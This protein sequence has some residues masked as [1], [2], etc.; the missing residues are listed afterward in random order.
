MRLSVILLA[1]LLG[2]CGDKVVSRAPW[3]SAA[4]EA[5][6]PAL[7]PGLWVAPITPDCHPDERKPPTAWPDCALAFVIRGDEMRALD[8]EE[9]SVNGKT[10]TTRLSWSSSQLILAAGDPSISQTAGCNEQA[11]PNLTVFQDPKAPP[12]P[13]PPPPYA[14]CYGGVRPTALDTA[15]RIVAFT[16][17]PVACGPTV[18]EGSTDK[19]EDQPLFPGLT[20]VGIDCTAGTIEA[21]RAAAA[22]SEAVAIKTEAAMH[23]ADPKTAAVNWFLVK[24]HWIRD[25]D[26]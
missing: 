3:F 24:A 15:G 7:R 13:P 14:Y 18:P 17:W 26:R 19:T 16:T 5:G 12:P 10:I 8:R 11:Q 2:G 4:D 22:E 23:A 21:L 1:L 25:S 20:R 9:T 6:A